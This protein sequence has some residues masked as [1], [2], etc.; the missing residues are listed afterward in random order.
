MTF[1]IDGRQYLLIAAG[2]HQVI[3]EEPLGD[4]I[5]AFTLP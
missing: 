2:G 5:V 4:T 1:M 3:P